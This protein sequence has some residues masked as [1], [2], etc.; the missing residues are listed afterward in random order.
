MSRNAGF[1]IEGVE[2]IIA[3]LAKTANEMEKAG[4]RARR[5]GAE[6]VAEE[7]KKNTP[8]STR[9]SRSTKREYG[10][11]LKDNVVI[12]GQRKDKDFGDKFV[13]VGWPKG[14]SWRV[15]FVNFGTIFQQPSGFIQKTVNSSGA[16]VQQAMVDEVRKV[17]K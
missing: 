15:H 11:H 5:A 7:L 2:E 3:N 16:K 8:K 4:N 12:S 1:R 14:M 9:K 10:D 6:V 13:A 17:F